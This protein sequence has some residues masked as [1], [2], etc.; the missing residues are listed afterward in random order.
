M[1][2]RTNLA[3]PTSSLYLEKRCRFR[4]FYQSFLL[5]EENKKA[6]KESFLILLPGA[7]RGLKK[8]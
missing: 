1:M 4:E 5:T 2:A 6:T 3:Q 8:I 7:Q